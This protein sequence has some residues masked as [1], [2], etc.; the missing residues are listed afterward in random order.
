MG[1]PSG[2]WRCSPEDTYLRGCLRHQLRRTFSLV[3]GQHSFRFPFCATA[4]TL[5][6]QLWL[7]SCIRG[8]DMIIYLYSM[9]FCNWEFH[10][11]TSGASTTQS[12]FDSSMAFC[13]LG[14]VVLVR[15]GKMKIHDSRLSRLIILFLRSCQSFS[16]YAE[17]SVYEWGRAVKSVNSFLAG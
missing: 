13:R 4:V 3:S 9:R 7:R 14:R 1:E 16:S 6:R 12:L 2:D 10:A 17:T 15:I 11:G 5:G 8:R